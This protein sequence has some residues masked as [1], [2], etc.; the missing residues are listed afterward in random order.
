MVEARWLRWFGPGVVALGAVGLVGSTTLGA[1]TR[2]WDL[3]ACG[4]P[5][6]DRSVAARDPAA[7]DLSDLGT[8]PWFRLDPLLDRDGALAGQ[9]LAVGLDGAP[10]GSTLDLPAELFAAGP[11]GRVVLVGTDDGVTSR[12]RALDVA[13]SCTWPIAVEPSVIRRATIDPAGTGIYEMRVDRATRADQG[14]WFRPI[15]GHLAA[16]QVLPPPAVDGR[17]GQ[18][19][20][21]EF[22]WEIAGDRLAVQSC[23]DAACRTRIIDP[24][25]GPTT[26]IDAPDLG[27]MIGFDEDRIV[28]YGACRGLPCPILATDLETGDRLTL[29]QAAGPAI[30]VATSDGARLVDEVPLAAGRGLRSVPLDGGG[31]TDLGPIDDGLDLQAAPFQADAA[32]RVPDGWVLLVPD[33]RMPPDGRSSAARLRRVPDGMTVSLAEAAR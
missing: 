14:I 17:F 10:G 15:D 29:A 1:G 3:Q 6:V 2:P 33:G 22:T 19:W 31:S 5:P 30:V 7:A 32:T 18:T 24:D 27:A 20:S 4:G 21:T 26:T 8:A 12:L 16:R 9:R 28:T 23:G 11:F 25:G 13:A